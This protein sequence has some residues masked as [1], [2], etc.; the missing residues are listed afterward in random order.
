MKL[1]SMLL[2]TGA[3][4][5]FGADETPSKLHFPEPPRNSN[6]LFYIQQSNNTNT[7]MYEANLR[8]DKK[9]DQESPMN[10]YWI[11]YA[12]HGQREDL[13]TLQWQLAYGYKHHSSTSANTYEISL[14]AFKKRQIWVTYQDNKPVAMMHINGHK[15]LLQKVF[16]QLANNAFIPKVKYIELFGLDTDTHVK[17]YERIDIQ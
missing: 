15:V 9:L 11:R 13:S 6:H 2:F 16:V 7:V 17:A 8:S 14:N 3:M 5:I 1:V 4:G 10:V 12:E